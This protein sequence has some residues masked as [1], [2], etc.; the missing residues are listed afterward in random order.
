M[1]TFFSRA[2]YSLVFA[3]RGLREYALLYIMYDL[4]RE[5]KKFGEMIIFGGGFTHSEEHFV[6]WN[7]KLN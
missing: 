6:L 7:K 5:K 1:F 3:C 4:M 2:A